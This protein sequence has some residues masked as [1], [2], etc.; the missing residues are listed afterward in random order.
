[1]KV[2]MKTIASEYS[3]LTGVSKITLWTDLGCFEGVAKL[4]PDDKEVA[5]HF[6]GCRYA[7]MRAMIKY[8]KAKIKVIDNQV[9]LLK[10]IANELKNKKLYKANSTGIKLLEKNIYL[11]EDDKEIFKD[12]IRSLTEKIQHDIKQRDE[13]LKARKEQSK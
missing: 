11:L 1:M 12:R 13:L 6:A 3:E 4:H 7:E 9:S 8:A 2:Q 10:N 5:S